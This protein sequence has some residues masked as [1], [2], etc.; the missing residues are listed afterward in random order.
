MTA[1][2]SRT[3]RVQ[4]LFGSHQ[5]TKRLSTSQIGSYRNVGQPRTQGKRI[6]SAVAE[7]LH[8]LVPRVGVVQR[9]R[10]RERRTDKHHVRAKG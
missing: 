5:D 6:R 4:I 7:A 2:S 3:A 10:L 8:A 1:R 9:A